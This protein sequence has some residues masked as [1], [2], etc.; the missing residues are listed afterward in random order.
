MFAMIQSI[1]VAI[2]VMHKFAGI[3]CGH[4]RAQL[5]RQMAP[6]NRKE[7]EGTRAY[8]RLQRIIHNLIARLDGPLHFR[9]I[10]Q[11][12]MASTFAVI[13]GLRDAKSG[14][15]AYFWAMLVNSGHRKE[16]LKVGWKRVGKIFI[17]AVILDFVYQI[18]VNH[19]FYPGETLIVAT[20]AGHRA[21]PY[22]ARSDQSPCPDAQ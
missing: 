4:T 9:L 6:A 14:K 7:W 15:P 1:R 18:K 2:Q 20:G 16:L 5:R 13:D 11:P 17:L 19:W 10:V 8:G 22:I 21:L 3:H 12:L